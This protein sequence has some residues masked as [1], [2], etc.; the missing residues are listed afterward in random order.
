VG[1]LEKE[2]GREPLVLVTVSVK[3]DMDEKVTLFKYLEKKSNQDIR[4]VHLAYHA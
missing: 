2:K 4:T 3:D 1:V